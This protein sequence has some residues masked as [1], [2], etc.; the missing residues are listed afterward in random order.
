MKDGGV[1]KEM[2]LLECYK[3][4]ELIELW[5][6]D[7]K[8]PAIKLRWYATS[9]AILDT[10]EA[11][12]ERRLED[13]EEVKKADIELIKIV[14][15]EGADPPYSDDPEKYPITHWWWHLDKIADR[16]YDASLLSEYLMEIYLK[17]LQGDFE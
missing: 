5:Q 17:A 6:Q 10:R 1:L 15:K 8:P 11:I 14:L 16:T 9:A 3:D 13:Q 4:E 2:G 7:C 12:F